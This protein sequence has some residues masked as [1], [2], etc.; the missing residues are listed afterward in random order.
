MTAQQPYH[1]KA[2]DWLATNALYLSNRNAISIV[3]LPK[4]A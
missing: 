1:Q 4:S 3:L 2:E